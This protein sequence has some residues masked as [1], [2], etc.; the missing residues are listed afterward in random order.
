MDC[1]GRLIGTEARRS[2]VRVLIRRQ[3]VVFAYFPLMYLKRTLKIGQLLLNELHVY[4][5][6]AV[7]YASLNKTSMWMYHI[8]C[9]YCH[10]CW[11]ILAQIKVPCYVCDKREHDV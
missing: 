7:K 8:Y 10:S 1:C 9:V 4:I 11:Y 3:S 2:L 6:Y 5:K